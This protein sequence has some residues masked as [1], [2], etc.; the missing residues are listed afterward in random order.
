M[1]QGR[2]QGVVRAISAHGRNRIR[3]GKVHPA[4]PQNA[5][6]SSV[7][8][9]VV[10]QVD[11]VCQISKSSLPVKAERL[12]PTSHQEGPATGPVLRASHASAKRSIG[13]S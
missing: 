12:I 3:V 6:A 5:T 13:D 9:F 10:H 1:E 11:L 4:T 7:D 8:P 2:L